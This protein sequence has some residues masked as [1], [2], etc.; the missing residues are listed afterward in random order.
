VSADTARRRVL[1]ANLEP[2]ALL[3][4]RQLL[5]DLGLE[6]V[7]DGG[8]TRAIAAEARRVSPDAVVLGRP[9]TGTSELRAQIRAAAPGAK[10]LVWER[11]ETAIEVYE[12]GSTSSRR[13]DTDVRAA[14][15]SELG[16]VQP[17]GEGK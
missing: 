12:P 9:D 6:V 2:I 4:M 14:L 17:N 13:V 16:A 10:V 7:T 11:D 8:S 5:E 15:L 3:G 1:L